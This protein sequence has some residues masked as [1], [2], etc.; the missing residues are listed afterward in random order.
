MNRKKYPFDALE[1][2]D[3]FDV[4]EDSVKLQSLRVYASK[5]GEALGRRFSVRHIKDECVYEV[6]R[7]PD[8]LPELTPIRKARP[9]ASATTMRDR[10]AAVGAVKL[11]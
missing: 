5:Q 10:A 6:S 1:P 2:G 3:A 11:A 9:V 7:L 4:P 8:D